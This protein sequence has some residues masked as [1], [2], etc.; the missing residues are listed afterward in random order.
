MSR[1]TSNAL[2]FTTKPILVRRLLLNVGG[3]HGLVGLKTMT[4]KRKEWGD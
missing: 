3:F 1:T 4:L 2:W